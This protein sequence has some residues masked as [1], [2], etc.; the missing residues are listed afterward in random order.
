M[1]KKIESDQQALAWRAEQVDDLQAGKD[2]WER[3]STALRNQLQGT[4]QQLA[5]ASDTLAGIYASRGWKLIMKLRSIRDRF[6]G[7]GKSRG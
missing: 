7:P 6:K 2:Y 4:Q 1:E 5:V 3:E